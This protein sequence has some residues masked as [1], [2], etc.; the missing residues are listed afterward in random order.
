L[1][2]DIGH[3]CDPLCVMAAARRPSASFIS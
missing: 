3:D 1:R 2:G